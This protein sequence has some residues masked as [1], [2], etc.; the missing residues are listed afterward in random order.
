MCESVSVCLCVCVCVCVCVSDVSKYVSVP[1]QVCV[2]MHIYVESEIHTGFLPLLL[3]TSVSETASLHLRPISL[4]RPADHPE[5]K[6][7][8]VLFL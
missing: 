7:F 8:L 2:H 5:E 1:W 4:A 3:A 6:I